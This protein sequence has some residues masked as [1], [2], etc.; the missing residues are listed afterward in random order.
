LLIP[1]SASKSIA[2][3]AN[4]ACKPW[5][6]IPVMLCVLTVLKAPRCSPS[7]GLQVDMLQ[8]LELQAAALMLRLEQLRRVVT[9]TACQYRTFCTWLLKTIQQLERTQDANGAL[10]GI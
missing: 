10:G 8:Q 9:S 7:C 6:H 5:S 4:S 1:L 3:I 2:S